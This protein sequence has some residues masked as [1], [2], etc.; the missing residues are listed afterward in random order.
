MKVSQALSMAPAGRSLAGWL[1]EVEVSAHGG[2][3]SSGHLLPWLRLGA[4][5]KPL[6]ATTIILPLGTFLLLIIHWKGLWDKLKIPR[7][8]LSPPHGLFG[9]QA[10]RSWAYSERNS[11]RE[12][13][14]ECHAT[15]Q[16]SLAQGTEHSR[17]GG[18]WIF[19]FHQ[20]PMEKF[21]LNLLC[22]EVSTGKHSLSSLCFLFSFMILNYYFCFR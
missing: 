1:T 7:E 2:G 19:K 8:G 16:P 9:C 22:H 11:I 18:R 5:S 21:S 6:H 17:S 14:R 4:S 3:R 10:M 20:E 13:D 12:G 15:A